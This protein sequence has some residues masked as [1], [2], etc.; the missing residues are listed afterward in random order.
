MVTH[1]KAETRALAETDRQRLWHPFTQMQEYAALEPLVVDRGEGCYLIDTDG[2]RYLDG[3]ASL[4]ANVHGHHHPR[5]TAAIQAQADRIA[6]STLLGLTNVPAV[7]LAEQLIR[8]APEGLTRVFYAEN[9]ASAV[10]IAVKM[11]FQYWRLR[12]R[13]ERTRFLSLQNGYHGDTLGAVSVGGIDLFHAAFQPLIFPALHAP[14]PY[15]Y[16]CP[17]QKTYPDCATACVRELERLV[18]ENASV[19]AAVIV[20]PLVQGAGGMITAPSGYLRSV[21]EACDRY[22]VLLIVDEVATGFGRTGTMFA[23]QQEYVLPDLM[24]VGKGITGGY[25]PLSATLVR[26]KVYEEFLGPYEAGRTFY[27]GHT[28]TGNQ[29]C[30]AAALANLEVFESERTLEE[31]QPKIEHLSERLEKIRDLPHVGDVRQRGFMVGIE[32]VEDRETRKQYSPVG[33]HARDVIARARAR[34]VV[35]RPLDDVVVLMPPLAIS[36]PE[37]DQLLDVTLASI[38]DA[39]E[40]TM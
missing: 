34:G 13:P 21:R 3:V 37:L 15:C 32:L 12:G 6:H 7:E 24:T 28:Y 33:A 9:G 38:R 10:E 16:R 22:D 5:I 26:E 27:H 36:I 29:L 2:N 25:L 40:A 20:E 35:I 8:I 1:L 4:W 39:T 31:L 19:L 30:C 18:A 17:L 23:C 14:S 11:A